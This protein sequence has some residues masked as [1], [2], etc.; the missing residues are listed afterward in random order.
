VASPK[1]ESQLS[2]NTTNPNLHGPQLSSN[3]RWGVDFA[4]FFTSAN[5]RLTGACGSGNGSVL[6][7]TSNVAD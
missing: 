1:F 5:V 7:N 3:Q 6:V 4:A 2:G